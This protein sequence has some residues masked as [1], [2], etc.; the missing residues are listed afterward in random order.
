VNCMPHASFQ[1]CYKQRQHR[2]ERRVQAQ[3]T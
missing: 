1:E 2:S 3:G